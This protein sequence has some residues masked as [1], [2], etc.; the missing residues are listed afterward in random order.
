MKT[1]VVVLPK[2]WTFEQAEKFVSEESGGAC[3]LLSIEKIKKRNVM[4]VKCIC[5][6]SFDVMFYQFKDGKHK[7]NDCNE[8][9]RYSIE[10][11]KTYVKENSDCLLLSETYLNNNQLLF[12]KCCCGESFETTFKRFRNGKKQCKSCTSS[13][14]ANKFSKSANE[15]KKEVFANVGVEYSVIGKY[16]NTK[17]KVELK[18]NVCGT[19]WFVNPSDFLHKKSRCPFCNKSKGEKVII[20][21][22][23]N[24]NFTFET[25]YKF[26]DCVHKRMLPFDFAI[27][28]NGDLSILIE[29]DGKQHF[30]EGCFGTDDYKE[31][32]MRDKIKTNYC[33]SK[34]IPLLRIPYTKFNT[35]T[36]ILEN[37][38]L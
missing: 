31:M 29:Y 28:K 24:N 4:K 25:Q 30:F 21:W 13:N 15:F 7:C 18:H 20:E 27:F 12:F 33:Q 2:K 22:L 6:S 19:N 36:L 9:Y 8:K 10:Q 14:L 35:I 11:L 32:K 37:T 5:G 1:E 16:Q 26:K 17:T 38:L 23:T 34:N 3:E